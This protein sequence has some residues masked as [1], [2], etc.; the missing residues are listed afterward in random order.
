MTILAYNPLNN[1]PSNKKIRD[2]PTIKIGKSRI[3]L[4]F[5]IILVLCFINL[6]FFALSSYWI[7]VFNIASCIFL[8]CSVHFLLLIFLKKYKNNS[9]YPVLIS[10]KQ[11]VAILEKQNK[12][13][14]GCIRSITCW[15]WIVIIP[16]YSAE[17]RKTFTL[18][19]LKDSLTPDDN[20][21]LRR[22]IQSEF[23]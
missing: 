12:K 20:S 15:Q 22:W 3:W 11:G 13:R 8:W 10:V 14:Y 7:A 18:V 4:R 9:E 1:N 6:G 23:V 19:V 2:L 5:Q 16:F 21:L 17:L